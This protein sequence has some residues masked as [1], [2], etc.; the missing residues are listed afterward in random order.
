MAQLSDLEA[1]ITAIGESLSR[2]QTDVTAIIEK[3]K[4]AMSGA[5]SLVFVNFHGLTVG[6]ATTMR[7]ALKKDG[8]SYF[9]AKKTLVE[10]ALDSH[11]YAGAR[12]ALVGEFG[13][14][15]GADLVAP[16]RGIYE[17]QRKFKD[18]ATIVGGVFENAYMS[19]DEMT[20]IAAIPPQKTLYG[21][22]VNVIN[23]PI[24]GM[25]M[26]LDQIAKKAPPI[27]VAV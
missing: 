10:K 8:V 25:V 23:S 26:V 17:F 16:A 2:L 20:T 18:K 9:V 24:Q 7:K 4:T 12:P 19:K 13:M 3:L 5:K 22:L 11:K 14:A 6:E 21:M 1:A 15:Y 27:P